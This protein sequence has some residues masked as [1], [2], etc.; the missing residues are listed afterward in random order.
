M[1][2]HAILWYQQPYMH[3]CTSPP[4][5]VHSTPPYWACCPHPPYVMQRPLS[6][7]LIL[8]WMS[9]LTA[10]QTET[11]PLH[12]VAAVRD[13]CVRIRGSPC[14]MAPLAA[15][16]CN[17]DFVRQWVRDAHQ[18]LS[19]TNVVCFTCACARELHSATG[20]VYK[21]ITPC[22]WYSVL[23]DPSAV[24]LGRFFPGSCHRFRSCTGGIPVSPAV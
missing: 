1:F 7:L 5:C 18:P 3:Q 8:S 20:L 10:G 12:S 15:P 23:I 19:A 24:G 11:N 13:S 6:A 14:K 4:V 17:Q 9:C 16:V 2:L 22:A 21:I